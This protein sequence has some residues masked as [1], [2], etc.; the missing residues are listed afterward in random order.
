MKRIFVIASAGVLLGCA[1][2]QPGQSDQGSSGI[3]GTVPLGATVIEM[4]AVVVGWSTRRDL[5]GK[6]VLNDTGEVVGKIEDVIITPDNSISFAIIGV[7]GFLGLAK[8]DVAI[9]ADQ[10]EV[11][12]AKLVL[13]GATKAALRELPPFVYSRKQQ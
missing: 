9:P 4:E 8:H 1:G 6:P 12:G 11:V 5:L 2:M 3:A 10:L 13:P 7:G